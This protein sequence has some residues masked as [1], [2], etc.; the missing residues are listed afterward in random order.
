MDATNRQV[1]AKDSV[2]KLIGGNIC[3]FAVEAER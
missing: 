1:N 2:W 3:L